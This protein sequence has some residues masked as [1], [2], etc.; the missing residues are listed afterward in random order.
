MGDRR[1]LRQQILSHATTLAVATADPPPCATIGAAAV[2]HG[3][4]R[5]SCQGMV[6]VGVGVGL[7]HRCRCAMETRGTLAQLPEVVPI[8]GNGSYQ[9]TGRCER[10]APTE[11]QSG[12][13]GRFRAM[14]AAGLDKDV[15]FRAG[16]ASSGRRAPVLSSFSTFTAS[17]R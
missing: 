7:R 5:G 14:A 15:A 12:R 8:T 9:S 17:V 11:G 1:N 16:R 3:N 13:F 4:R 2:C 10:R 6:A